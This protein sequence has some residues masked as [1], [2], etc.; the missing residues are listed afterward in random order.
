MKTLYPIRKFY[1]TLGSNSFIKLHFVKIIH[2]NIAIFEYNYKSMLIEFI[3][4]FKSLENLVIIKQILICKNVSKHHFSRQN[5]IWNF[6]SKPHNH[7]TL[8]TYS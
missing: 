7:G 3:Q 1:H 6:P 2:S 5:N 4:N 8:I